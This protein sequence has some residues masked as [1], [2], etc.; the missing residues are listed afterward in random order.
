M[1]AMP[2]RGLRILAELLDAR[3]R[4]RDA[5]LPLASA[6]VDPSAPQ[7]SGDDVPRYDQLRQRITDQIG[8]DAHQR[9]ADQA[10]LLPRAQISGQALA[11]L[12]AVA[13][14]PM[15]DSARVR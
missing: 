9:L 15:T 2:T 13:R 11:V 8:A 5:A 3:G 1:P 6:S 4:P 12:D 14:Q 10:A 7:L